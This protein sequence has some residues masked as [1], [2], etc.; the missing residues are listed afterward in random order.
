M[1]SAAPPHFRGAD[2]ILANL[3][4]PILSTRDLE[5]LGRRKPLPLH[6]TPEVLDALCLFGVKAVYLAN[7]HMYDWNVSAA[8]TLSLLASVGVAGFGAGA[9]LAEANTPFIFDRGDT[10]VRVFAFGWSVIGCRPAASDRE[11][12]NSLTP[13][14]TLDTIRRLRNRDDCSFVVFVMHWN[15]ELERY[16]QPAHRQLAH[17]LIHEG[18]D[19]VIGLHSHVAQGAEL[20]DGKPVVYGLGNWLFPIRQ[21]GHLRLAYPSVTAR[22][23]A[24]ELDIENRRVMNVRFHWHQFDADRN[25]VRRERTEDWKGKILQHLTPYA[26]MSHQ[27]YLRWFK[28][29]RTRRRGLPVYEDYHHTCCNRVK[30]RYVKLR[31]AII[32]TLVRARLKGGPRG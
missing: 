23:L 9:D 24:V 3:E 26:G 32:E 25:S 22:E 28:A 31:Q 4:G 19:A 7:N 14:H 10:R 17:D 20:V 21:V 12:V 6:N 27:E 1:P 18:V 8:H 30:D 13:E 5:L 29:S 2:I 11:G 15:Y 16:P